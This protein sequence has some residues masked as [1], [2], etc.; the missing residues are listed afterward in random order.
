MN[1]EQS[2]L[3]PSVWAPQ[4]SQVT[5]YHGPGLTTQT[6]MHPANAARQGWWGSTEDLPAGTEYAFAVD[7]NPPRPDPRSLLQPRGP[8]EP[9]AVVDLTDFTWT[10]HGWPGRDVRGAVTYELHIGTFTP[11]GTLD[12]A[13]EKLSYLAHLGVD[14]IELMPV[15]EFPG[16]RGWGYD[17]VNLYA[18][19]HTYGGPHALQR[20]VNAAHNAGLGVILDVVYNH[21][22]PSGNYLDAFG[23]YF[24]EAHET[25]WGRAVNLDQDHSAEVRRWICDNALMWL[26]DF[27]IDALRLDAVHALV[28][29]SPEH[30]LAQLAR[31]T[32]DLAATL[33]RPCG[34]VAE[35]DLNNTVMITPTNDSGYGMTAQWADDVHHAIHAWLTGE[36]QGYYVDFGSTQALRKALTNGFLHDGTFSTFR[37]KDWGTP[38]PDD[39]D[40]H[41]FVVSTSNHD[42]VGN[43][44]IGDRPSASLSPGELA[45]SAALL[46]TAPFSPM[47][48]MGEEWGAKT[49]WRFFTDHDDPNLA[50]AITAGRTKEF[51]GHGWTELYGHEFTVPDPQDPAT[52][53]ASILN[54]SETTEPEH[55]RLLQ[56]YRDLIALRRDNQDLSSGNLSGTTVEEISTGVS[57]PA[58]PAPDSEGPA[59]EGPATGG[60]TNRSPLIVGRGETAVLINPTH[61]PVTFELPDHHRVLASW[62]PVSVTPDEVTVPGPGVAITGSAAHP[63]A[64]RAARPS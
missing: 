47:L 27:H 58:S 29:D 39:T 63:T 5:L 49:D 55:A 28:D 36:R 59:S 24:T 52:L 15:A 37:D 45:I 16:A 43:R 33:G 57:A 64:A 13:V 17:G 6:P 21:L 42:Q 22:G 38:V 2:G 53:Q 34:L 35:S 51:G 62:D 3:Q 7:D 19:H 14:L 11:E 4:A 1:P 32:Q 50:A 40:G 12:A 23:P 26:R 25:P 20:F 10:D 46:L 48:F 30:L 9:S 61:A 44:A 56:W 8:H 54:W 31:E 41:Q 60:P 18:V